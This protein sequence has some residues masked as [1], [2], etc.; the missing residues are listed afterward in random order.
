VA[1]DR[2]RPLPAVGAALAGVARQE[3]TGLVAAGFEAVEAGRSALVAA[4]DPARK[5]EKRIRRAR[6]QVRVRATAATGFAGLAAGA[7]VAPGL[8]V[9]E[10]GLGAVALVAGLQ[11]VRAGR[12]LGALRRLPVPLPRAGRPPRT[13]PA[14]EPLDRLAA[15][16]SSLHGL[17]AHLG[18]HGDEPRRV[19]AAAADRLRSLG[20]RLTAVDRAHR[21]AGGL[22][23]AVGA[24]RARLD[25]GVAAHAALV[26][27]AADAVA[28]DA[29]LAGPMHELHE[30]TD[31]LA[32]LA[33]GL[34]D[35]AA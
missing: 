3:L 11:A 6:R 21:T 29:G 2:P 22:T 34:R 20:A 13:S 24:L 18:E 35:L 1:A 4:K 32:G 28:A 8:E 5:H 9:A 16:E 23:E 33:A 7:L 30:A 14:R 25:A 10:Y 15:Q 31:T 12:R 17:L 19:A 26:V 27:A